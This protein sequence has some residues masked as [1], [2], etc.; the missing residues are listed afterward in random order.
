MALDLVIAVCSD[1]R[2]HY[3]NVDVQQLL[4]SIIKF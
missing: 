2:V 1:H 3:V 4:V